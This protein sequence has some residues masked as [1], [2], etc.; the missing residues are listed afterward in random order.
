MS[1]CIFCQIASKKIPS[2]I[3]YED[4]K[5][6]A[7]E[8]INPQAPVHI[9]IIPKNHYKDFANMLKEKKGSEDL[10]HLFN[11]VKEII[12]KKALEDGGFRI[13]IN[14]GKEAGQAVDHLHI[15]ILSGRYMN[16][17]PG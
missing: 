16:W 1:D 5:S 17:P 9:L 11:A 2:K 10:N 7:F 4:N 6:L 12:N 8:D 13:V 14:N 3:I 15:H